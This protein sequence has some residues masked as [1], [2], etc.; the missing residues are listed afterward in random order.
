MQQIR[1]TAV[2]RSRRIVL[3]FVASFLLNGPAKLL[4]QEGQFATKELYT[5]TKLVDL[6][7]PLVV[8][9]IAHAEPRRRGDLGVGIDRIGGSIETPAEPRRG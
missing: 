6:P 9:P 4:A 1:C 3:V 8:L 7:E 2:S 5:W